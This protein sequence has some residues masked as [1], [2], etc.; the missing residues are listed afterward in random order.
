[1]QP[2]INNLESVLMKISLDPHEELIGTLI[3]KARGICLFWLGM[4]SYWILKIIFG[5]LFFFF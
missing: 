5:T 4:N 1:M 2:I 3:R